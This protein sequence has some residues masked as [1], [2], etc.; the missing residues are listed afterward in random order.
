MKSANFDYA[1]AASVDE[2]CRLLAA[3]KGDGKIIA[4]GQTLVPLLVM[5]LARPSLL[6]DINRVGDLQGIEVEGDAIVVKACTRQSVALASAEVQAKAPL[7]AKA[8]SFVGHVQTRN[9]GSVGGSLANAD[10][11]AEIGLASVVLGAEIVAQR[12]GSKRTIPI[13]RFFLGP[14]TTCLE[15]DECLTAIRYPIWRDAGRIGTGFQELSA[16]RSDFALVAAAVQLVL[17]GAG[18]CR[19]AAVGIGGIAAT[20]IRA[21]RVAKRLVG[22]RLEEATLAAAVADLTDGLEILS[23]IHGSA[24]YRSRVAAALVT[25]AIEEAKRDASASKA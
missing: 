17:D 12:A 11:A 1:C 16:R 21:E 6:I 18:I 3:A 9:R 14:M 13:D 25:R 23:D 7:L 15:D 19:R 2:V 20:P 22:T 4:G 8:L 5:R 24:G 10:P